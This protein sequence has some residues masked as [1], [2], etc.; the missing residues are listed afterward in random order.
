MSALSPGEGN[1]LPKPTASALKGDGEAARESGTVKLER[2]ES[3]ISTV[4]CLGQGYLQVLNAT[5]M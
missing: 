2:E 4:V 5:E 1:H 3:N